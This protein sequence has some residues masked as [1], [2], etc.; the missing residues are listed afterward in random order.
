MMHLFLAKIK[1]A[2]TIFFIALACLLLPAI[3]SAKDF[4]GMYPLNKLQHVQKVYGDNIR[5]VLYEDIHHYLSPNQRESLATVKL[6]IPIYSSEAGI[7]DFQMNLQTGEMIIPALSIKFFDDIALA[8]AWYE[9]MQMDKAKIIEYIARL[10]SQ[11]NYLQPPLEALGVPEQAWKLSEYVD[12]VS[13][14]TLK[15]GLAFLLLHELGHWHYRHAS[16][17]TISNRQAQTQEMQ[18]DLMA[19]EVMGRMRT[20]PYGI[21]TWFLVTGLLQ[22]NNP[23]THP[24]SANRL[25]AITRKIEE[26]PALFISKENENTLSINEVLSVASS[27]RTIANEITTVKQ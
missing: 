9:H 23:T 13:Q 27:I 12:D 11:Q 5:G 8:F 14:K 1:S 20:I 6:R 15:S 2:S 19:L 18:S 26:N 22:D 24:L 10:Y 4:S 16:Y 21:V 3:S 7:F 25:Y 17:D